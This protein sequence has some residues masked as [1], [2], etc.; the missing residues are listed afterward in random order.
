M[1]YRQ[2][3]YLALQGNSVQCAEKQLEPPGGVASS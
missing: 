1:S 2:L 3:S